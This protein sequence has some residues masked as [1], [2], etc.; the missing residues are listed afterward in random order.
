M[1]SNT[2][3]GTA[4]EITSLPYTS[5]QVDLTGVGLSAYD[6]TCSTAHGGVWWKRTAGA[7]V[8]TI[9]FHAEDDSG[10]NNFPAVSIWDADLNQL[11]CANG[12]VAGSPA[13]SYYGVDI[14]AGATRYIQVTAD[15][16]VSSPAPIILSA[17]I[18]APQVI[19]AGSLCV[20]SDLNDTPCVIVSADDGSILWMGS[21]KLTEHGE[22]FGGVV[23]IDAWLEPST[24]HGFERYPDATRFQPRTTDGHTI[25]NQSFGT[26]PLRSDRSSRFFYCRVP[27]SGAAELL[28]VY[29]DGSAGNS[30]TL[31][32]NSELTKAGAPSRDRAI[33]YYQHSRAV[34]NSSI[35]RY[36]LVTPGALSDLI[37]TVAGSSRGRD[38]IVTADGDILSLYKPAA[39]DWVVQRITSA[40][41]VAATYAVG[42]SQTL[43]RMDFAVGD[44]AI[45]IMSFPEGAQHY[46]RFRKIQLSDGAELANFDVDHMQ[47]S[48]RTDELGVAQSCPIIVIQSEIAVPSTPVTFGTLGP[49][50]WVEAR[51]RIPGSP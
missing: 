40:G 27:S 41:S 48:L 28:E 5:G 2:T 44:L 12:N 35:H 43:P 42:T 11:A 31:P 39:S 49:L 19:P 20:P 45:W 15:F 29:P 7:S 47:L 8:E 4:I 16:G 6:P 18:V 50:A 36:D 46:S 17:L 51:W 14:P 23:A 38:I 1:P 13:R 3:P 24:V 37:A 33:Y 26:N 9:V 25:A 21:W 34:T 10:G 22:H 32:S 30:W